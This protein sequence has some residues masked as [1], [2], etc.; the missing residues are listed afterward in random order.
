LSST[1]SRCNTKT[2]VV[3]VG[4]V[5]TGEDDYGKTHGPISATQLD[6]FEFSDLFPI[7]A[8]LT[9]T[10]QSLGKLPILRWSV[11]HIPIIIKQ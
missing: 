1:S 5:A 8:Y 11:Y 2:S 10:Y 3:G 7:W 6:L 4:V 9:Y